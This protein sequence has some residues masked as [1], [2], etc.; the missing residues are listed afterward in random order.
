MISERQMADNL[1]VHSA[2]IIQAEIQ[3][4]RVLDRDLAVVRERL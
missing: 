1:A 3:K 2:C 4:E